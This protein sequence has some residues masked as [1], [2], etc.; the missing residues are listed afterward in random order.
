MNATGGP[1]FPCFDG[2]NSFPGMTRRD[3]FAAFA[4]H[5]ILSHP[6]QPLLRSGDSLI[7]QIA[8]QDTAE[9]AYAAADAMLAESLIDRTK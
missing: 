9:Y 7:Q 3:V 1:A 5:A 2:S 4:M 6:G 8:W